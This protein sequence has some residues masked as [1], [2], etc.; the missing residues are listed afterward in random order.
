MIL[1]NTTFVIRRDLEDEFLK[2]IRAEYI[3]SLQAHE[4]LTDPSLARVLTEI[5]PSALS[6]ALGI[7]APTLDEAMAW[8]D[9]PASALRE[10]A[11]RRW[12]ENFL[13][14]TTPLERLSHTL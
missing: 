6:F 14:F 11:S 5:D 9:G 13:T 12:G 4:A 7:T 2:W 8:H 1:L 10:E 3:P